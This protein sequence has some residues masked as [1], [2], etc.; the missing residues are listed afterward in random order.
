LNFALPCVCLK[1]IKE[2]GYLKQYEYPI[3]NLSSSD[4]GDIIN[5]EIPGLIERIKTYNIKGL[6]DEKTKVILIKKV[7]YEILTETLL[8]NKEIIFDRK[9]GI[10][11]LGY[12]KCFNEP[13]FVRGLKRIIYNT[14]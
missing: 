10:E 7:L 13:D 4:R 2:T 6:V 11:K 14:Y 3:N 8:K 12:P 5:N 1:D 9:A